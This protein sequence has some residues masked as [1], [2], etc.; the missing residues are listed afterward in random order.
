[1]KRLSST[2]LLSF[3]FLFSSLQAQMIINGQTLYGNEWINHS[4]DYYKL[5]VHEDGMYRISQQALVDA[6]IPVGAINAG[7]FQLYAMGNQVP[8]YASTGG[9]LGSSDYIEFY[10]K[11]NLGE[12]DKHLYSSPDDILNPY[13]S[14]FTD[15]TAYFL[16]WGSGSNNHIQDT[17]NNLTA[18]PAAESYFMDQALETFTLSQKK[19]HKGEP[20]G[21]LYESRF[22]PGEGF[23]Y[24]LQQTT[25]G[26]VT[27]S[28][29]HTG[30]PD[31]ELSVG[32]AA[33]GAGANHHL[34]I[35]VNGAAVAIDSATFYN[36]V[37]RQ[38]KEDIPT[39]M[40]M[41]GANAL[42]VKGLLGAT[43]QYATGFMRVIYPRNFSFGN[44]DNFQFN[45]PADP[46]NKKYLEITNFN[47]G[48]V[49]PVLYDLTNGL[50]ITTALNGSTVRV[51]LPPSGSDR[52]LVLVSE[53]HTRTMLTPNEVN[54]IDYSAT[55]NQGDYIIVSNPLLM[56]DGAGNNY[57]QEYADYR[58]STGYDVIIITT[59]QLYDQFGYGISRHSQSVR[60]LTG[61]SL[62]NWSPR[63]RYMFMIGK[64]RPY[65]STR[66]N[67]NKQPAF[68]TTFGHEPSDMLLTAT[69]QSDAPRLAFGK[70]PVTT[71]DQIALYLNKMM[72]YENTNASLP[73]TIED[74]EWRKRVIHMGGG[75]ANIQSTIINNLGNYEAQVS[76]EYYGANVESFIQN[77][78]VPTV[79][80]ASRRLDS[81]IA[82]GASLLTF[83]GHSTPNNIDFNLKL[84]GEYDNVNKFP[85]F[86]SLGCYNGQIHTKTFG[87]SEQFVFEPDRG[88]IAFLA[89]IGLSSLGALDVFADAFYLKM[90]KDNY[91]EGIGDIAQAAV[92]SLAE[93]LNVYNRIVYQQ[94]T[95]NGDPAVRLNNDLAPDYTVRE[96]AFEFGP[97]EPKSTEEIELSFNLV[98]LG[99]TDDTQ[100]RVLIERVLPDGTTVTVLSDLIDAPSFEET[101]TYTIPPIVDA[102]GM[103]EFIVT[104]DSDN[105][106]VELPDP[107]AENNNTASASVFVYADVVTPIAPRDYSIQ[108]DANNITLQAQIHPSYAGQNL[109]Y[110]IEI[111]TTEMYNSPLY[112]STSIQQTGGILEWTPPVSYTNE[113]VYYW[114]VRVE[115]SQVANAAGW[116][117]MSYVYIDG[118]YPGWNQSHHYQFLDD[119][120]PNTLT[121]NEDTREF[122]FLNGGIE[123]VVSNAH[124]GV[125]PYDKIDYSI[126]GSRIYDVEVCEID[127]KGIYIALLDENG[128][129][130]WNDA[131]DLATNLGQYGSYICK[132]TQPAYT[133]CT[134]DAAGQQNLED[135]LVN[136]L[137]TL[138]DVHDVLIYS[139]NDYLPETWDQSLF[140]A[141]ANLGI[142]ELQSSAALGGVP[143]AA[144]VDLEDN[145]V[146]EEIAASEG[147]IIEAIFSIK[148]PWDNGTMFSTIIGPASE[149]GSVQWG[150]TGQEDH[151]EAYINIYGIDANGN[152]TT[153]PIIS[154]LTA[155][156][157]I[158]DG[159]NAIDPAQYPYLQLEYVTSDPVNNTPA[160]LDF[161]RIIYEDSP[162]YQLNITA[163]LEGAYDA[164]S[165][166]MTTRLGGER[167]IL[168][169]QT[170]ISPL[171]P[172]TPAGHPYSVAPWN[173]TG[174]EGAGFTDANYTGNEVDWILVSV[175]TATSKTSE[176][177]AAAGLLM[178]D[179]TINFTAQCPLETTH[180]G[181]FYVVVEHRN[182]MGI[183]T[184]QPVTVVNKEI[185]YDFTAQDSYRDAAGTG[186]G[187]KEIAPGVWVML[188]GDMAQTNDVV[189]YDITG[190]DKI[191]WTDGNGNFD[192][193]RYS[194]AN[195]DGDTNGS[196]KIYWEINNGKSSRVPRQ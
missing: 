86:F 77:S 111:D 71:P 170:P 176:E 124:V 97:E 129:P 174:T 36:Y 151:D 196:D 138:T 114:R 118:E 186:V 43:D 104:V 91:G 34:Q 5:Y 103:N 106:I 187:Q 168:P 40:L 179:G 150:V 78:S 113:T 79:G 19:Y 181:P 4:Q 50:R 52:E 133:F 119:R 185:I 7:D 98:N 48:G 107:S 24:K 99:R 171:V 143:Y 16:T 163:I 159:N 161:W 92:A 164:A 157:L 183:M 75:D 109:T 21:G 189:S 15:T 42:E 190:A 117:D 100:V 122:E 22:S 73:Q 1:M 89:T 3:L 130:I 180:P 64:S 195:L 123:V 57:V 192:S 44:A 154:G 63:P 66:K 46:S 188:S 31:A 88:T 13:F 6:G 27:I 182:H 54:F 47:H 67:W 76:D 61:Y 167:K 121:Y 132:S 26:T 193:Y 55:T 12:M 120:Y 149:W 35:S 23:G 82:E 148:D 93:D 126:G 156:E 139:L 194:D 116:Q 2:A 45:L 33:S 53:N 137:P 51:A 158:F 127:K 134:E 184:P 74:R 72:I 105:V 17:P 94:M 140:N 102:V 177:A 128:D 41:N 169:G 155:N 96:S 10:G 147:D 14:M 28:D 38:V 49:A 95:V 101:Y 145:S 80:S 112:Q 162:C 146:Q 9:T 90:S 56:D 108:P 160:Q 173:H 110:Y 144:L 166:D 62:A 172:P 125:L 135:F 65:Y 83:Y 141:F 70:L 85:I 58:T 191:I 8:I 165:G 136:T 30:G 11:E 37:H 29:L 25:P 175:R 131:V 152:R 153:Q 84:P 142:T 39:S 81:L 69:I 32:L 115:P 68:T 178:K 87:M 20:Y 59:D 60:N 18:L